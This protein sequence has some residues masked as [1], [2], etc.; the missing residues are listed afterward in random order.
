MLEILIGFQITN[1]ESTAFG[2]NFDWQSRA[3]FAPR[4][5]P[6]IV[7]TAFACQAFVEA[8]QLF[9]DD[10]YLQIGKQICEFIVNDLNRIDETADKVS[11][12]YTP[13][14]KSVIFNASLLAG[15]CLANVGNLTK[16]QDYL[17]LAE[18][19]ARY[20]LHRQNE[21]GA[22]AYGSKLRHKWIDN[23]HTAYVLLSIYRLQKLIPALANDSKT[24]LNIGY[25]FWI[26]NFFLA[27][28][29]PKYYNNAVY[30]IDIHSASA[31]VAALAELNDFNGSSL[32]WQR[33][34]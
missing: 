3:F 29:T 14:D 25:K 34:Y 11:L 1:G 32:R 21:D 31:A 10:R 26:E 23:F 20:V 19:I 22:W 18:K 7:P 17:K 8:Y 9:R 16:N 24:A 30:P 12:S 4:G 15:E 13:L 5:T 28:G 6:T 27:D 2:Y 33:K